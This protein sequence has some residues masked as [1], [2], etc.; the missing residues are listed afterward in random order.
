MEG[1]SLWRLHQKKHLFFS[2]F[3]DKLVVFFV[4]ELNIM[5]SCTVFFQTKLLNLFSNT[6]IQA[7]T[8][9]TI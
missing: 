6:E 8:G 2:G 3:P 9:V 4:F 1:N 5:S 7:F